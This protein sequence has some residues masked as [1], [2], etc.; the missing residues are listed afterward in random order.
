M[1]IQTSEFPQSKKKNDSIYSS[2]FRESFYKVLC[3]VASRDWLGEKKMR[4]IA[5]EPEFK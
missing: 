5:L 3:S 2:N 4:Q 1:K